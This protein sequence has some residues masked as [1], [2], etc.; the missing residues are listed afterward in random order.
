[1]IL[2]LLP[3]LLI[4]ECRIIDEFWASSPIS[5]KQMF[6]WCQF[7]D[8]HVTTYHLIIGVRL[9]W[10]TELGLLT[11][12]QFLQFDWNNILQLKTN[13]HSFMMGFNLMMT[14]DVQGRE[15]LDEVL[16]RLKAEDPEYT[17][18][19]FDTFSRVAIRRLGRLLP[20]ARMV[21]MQFSRT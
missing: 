15:S 11:L 8:P 16:E 18:E 5:C 12:L 7:L 17:E 1:M 21:I 4:I 13:L 20:D 9:K 19:T 3:I 2:H 6:F 10:V 14:F